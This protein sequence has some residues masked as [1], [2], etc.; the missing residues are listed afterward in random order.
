MTP[1]LA[2]SPISGYL[3][4]C[5]IESL[6]RSFE[7][8]QERVSVQEA[9]KLEAF[10]SWAQENEIDPRSL[11]DNPDNLY[12][13]IELYNKILRTDPKQFGSVFGFNYRDIESAPEQMK[14]PRHRS[15]HSDEH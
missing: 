5:E 6:T 12:S 1:F 3:F 15:E 10:I 14:C 13:L 7:M 4:Y 9:E 8:R 2:M 11:C